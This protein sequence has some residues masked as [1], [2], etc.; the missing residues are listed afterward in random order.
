MTATVAALCKTSTAFA[1][2]NSGVVGS[3]PVRDVQRYLLQ[4]PRCVRHQLSSSSQTVELWVRIP[5]EIYRDVC[6]FSRVCVVLYVCRG[7][8]YGSS[9]VQTLQVYIW[10]RNWRSR[11]SPNKGF[12]SHNK[13]FLD[14]YS[15][16]KARD[17]WLFT[18][19]SSTNLQ[20]LLKY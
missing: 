11:P 2:S 4:L 5:L 16:W 20:L 13:C 15:G 3:N 8:K 7:L 12:C 19:C 14:L 17:T 9:L 6:V 1:L 18:F 10:L